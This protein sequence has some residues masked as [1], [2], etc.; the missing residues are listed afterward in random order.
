MFAPPIPDKAGRG[1][2]CSRIHQL[3]KD[4]QL[5]QRGGVKENPR[6]LSRLLSRLDKERVLLHKL[7]GKETK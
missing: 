6:E 3:T 1:A 4:I 7:Y 5:F 2:I